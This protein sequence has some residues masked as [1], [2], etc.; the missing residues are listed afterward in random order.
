MKELCWYEWKLIECLE[1]GQIRPLLQKCVKLWI[2][3][4]EWKCGFNVSEIVS[5]ERVRT[6][7]QNCNWNIREE[8]KLMEGICETIVSMEVVTEWILSGEEKLRRVVRDENNNEQVL[9]NQENMREWRVSQW[10]KGNGCNVLTIV[11]LSTKCKTLSIVEQFA[12]VNQEELRS[13][14]R[15]NHW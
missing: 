2:N 14:V 12:I 7:S 5:R 1:E 11:K 8:T 4:L 13:V 9:K 3:R 10:M 15:V 6:I